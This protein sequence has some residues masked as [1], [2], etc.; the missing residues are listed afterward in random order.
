MRS[1]GTLIARG[2]GIAGLTPA[3]KVT[4]RMLRYICAVGHRA[5]FEAEWLSGSPPEWYDHLIF[6]YWQWFFTRNPMSLERGVF[7]LLTMKHGCRVLDLC[8]GGGF[9]AYHFYSSRAGQVISVD[10]DR[11]AISHARRNFVAS[12]LEYRCA[13]VRT[14]MPEGPFDNIV[15]DAAIEHFT[16]DETKT[17]LAN[18]KSRLG[19]TGTLSGYAIAAKPS[20][21]SLPQHEF[22]YQSKEDL[23]AFLKRFFPNVLV[24]E[25]VSRDIMEERRNF[26]FMASFSNLPFDAGWES[27]VRL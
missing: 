4:N 7:N 5:Q 26:Y 2:L 12:N 24:F 21:K 16:V 3:I 20:G 27:M 18:I 1:V 6:Q 13:D 17:I 14:D 15:W 8:C 9:F 22:E 10:F 11:K 19:E 23:A 25:N